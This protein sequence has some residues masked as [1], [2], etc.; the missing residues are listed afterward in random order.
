MSTLSS[1]SSLSTTRGITAAQLK[2]MWRRCLCRNQHRLSMATY[3]IHALLLYI[4][5]R[6]SSLLV[7]SQPNEYSRQQISH[8]QLIQRKSQLC[9]RYHY[10]SLHS[11][12]SVPRFPMKCYHIVHGWGGL[13]G[14][15]VNQV[16]LDSEHSLRPY[17][18]D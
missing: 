6:H 8:L 16:P 11:M 4:L 13:V 18:H 12:K 1:P 5:Q 15:W 14:M 7:L 9:N 17:H 2:T 3:G 10:F